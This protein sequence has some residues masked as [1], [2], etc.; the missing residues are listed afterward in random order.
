MKINTI[1]QVKFNNN[2]A[3]HIQNS[4][5]ENGNISQSGVYNP[6]YYK[7]YNIKINFGKR[8]PEDFYTQDFNRENMPSTMKKYLN[9][10]YTN[11][12]KLAPVQVMQEAYDNLHQ[13]MTV[14]D[15]KKLFPNEEKFQKLIPANYNR[16]THGILRDIKE[17]KAMQDT[18]EPL[19]KDGCDDLTTYLVKKIYLEGK[20]VKEI[21]KDFAK[22]INEVYQLAARVPADKAKTLGKN[23]SAYF[24]HTTVYRLGIRFP[25]LAFWNSF[26]ATRDDY[27]RVKRVKT[28]DGRFVDASSAEG[29]AILKRR[30]EPKVKIE[31]PEPRKYNFKRENVKR[32]TDSILNT[33][34]GG[35]KAIKELNRKG[36][37]REELS[38]LQQYWSEIMSVATEKI[39]LSEELI[40][41]NTTKKIEEQKVTQNILE[42]LINCDELT[43][44][45]QTPLQIFWNQR[46]ELKKHFSTA[47][48]DTMMLF[49]E[50]YGSDGTNKRFQQLVD[51]AQSIK[52][53]R[54]AKLLEHA[55]I[56]EEYDEL[57]KELDEL[58]AKKLEEIKPTPIIETPTE[59]TKLEAPKVY[60]Y[61]IKG[62]EVTTDI[63]VVAQGKQA[64]RSVFDLFPNQTHA[65]YLKELEAYIAPFYHQFWLS[66]QIDPND[67]N[68]SEKLKK[69]ILP[70]EEMNEIHR[71]IADIMEDKH[72]PILEKTRISLELFALEKNIIPSEELHQYGAKDL[73]KLKDKITEA[74]GS[75]EEIQKAQKDI[76]KIF[77]S[78][79]QPLSNKERVKI[80]MDL[81]Q[82]LK[83]YTGNRSIYAGTIIEPLIHL[84]SESANDKNYTDTFKKVFA[85]NEQ[86][87]D[88][89]GPVL[90]YL[91]DPNGNKEIKNILR[92]HCYNAFIGLDTDQ[93]SIYITR[94]NEL[95]ER[96]LRGY[97]D[98]IEMFK[99]LARRVLKATIKLK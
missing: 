14:D 2:H 32:I 29:R 34:E 85:R 69:V 61:M 16:A 42:K 51:Y 76:Q 57:G 55:R 56:Q 25:E 73:I 49:T 35:K 58:D 97:P 50:T 72:N 65:A 30:E 62:Q 88:K 7:D 33:R 52:P 5:H 53:N 11:R 75:E 46:P 9:E 45:E 13:A 23:E 10:D 47:I 99:T 78:F 40:D 80:K 81:F 12:S 19:F 37:N 3:Y 70:I 44:K 68:T 98:E 24:A 66:S 83:N 21:D 18:P 17:I 89:E 79:S 59:P 67:A 92:E 31:T 84:L 20:T 96:L 95:M 90:R 91:L 71:N 36:Y 74:L 22:D 4:A 26:I 1:T 6:I 41:F 94:D 93:A 63:D 60:K 86:V 38:F 8:S 48:T 77:N 64:F 43:K 54:E 15:I 87:L 39:H 82:G 27:D 28:S